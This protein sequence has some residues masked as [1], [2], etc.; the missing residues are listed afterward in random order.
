[1]NGHTD[2]IMGAIVTNNEEV[3]TKLRFLQNGECFFKHN[4][5]SVSFCVTI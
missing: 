2:V 1:M 3:Y 5:F 4:F